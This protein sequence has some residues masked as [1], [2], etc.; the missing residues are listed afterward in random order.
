VFSPPLSLVIQKF[1]GNA[2]NLTREYHDVAEMH[3][4]DRGPFRCGPG[5]RSGDAELSH[6]DRAGFEHVSVFFIP[7]SLPDSDLHRDADNP[8]TPGECPVLN[9]LFRRTTDVHI[10]FSAHLDVRG[11]GPALITKPRVWILSAGM[12]S[13]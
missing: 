13:A 6:A 8:T 12:P 3:F 11:P 10:A 7:R 4:S 9:L 1:D 2:F 5:R